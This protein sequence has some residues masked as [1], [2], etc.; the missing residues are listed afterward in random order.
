MRKIVMIAF[1]AGVAFAQ[2]ADEFDAWMRTIDEKNQSVQRNIADKDG[3][4]AADDARALQDTFKL[5]EGFW[6][7]RGDAPDAVELSQKAGE[8][9]AE[10]A[11]LIATK[12]FDAASTQSIKIAETCTACH[13][14]YRP[15]F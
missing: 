8:R 9:A 5:V 10:V 11:K 3:K 1:A 15:L 14:L 2:S 4:S 7:K 6:K 12:D 13:R